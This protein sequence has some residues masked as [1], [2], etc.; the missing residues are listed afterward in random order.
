EFKPM[1]A[2]LAVAKL[3]PISSE[4]ARLMQDPAEI[5][6]ILGQGAAR[7]RE[8]ASPILQKTYE[9]VGMIRS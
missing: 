2:D 3:S 4:M 8:I 9:I 1:L 7:A 5:D 6:R